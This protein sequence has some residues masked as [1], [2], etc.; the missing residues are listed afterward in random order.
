MPA[1]RVT[2]LLPLAAAL[3]AALAL[4]AHGQ[5]LLTLY[6]AARDYDA[7]YQSA[8]AQFDA[9]LARAA[10][11]KA[12]ILPQVGAQASVQRN[13]FDIDVISGAPPGSGERNFN[14]QS[15]A[16]SATQPLY[17]PAAWAA[18]EQGKRQAEIAQTVLATAEQDLIVRVSQ[19]YFDVLAAQDT[20][21]LVRAQKTAVAPRP[22]PIRARPRPA[23]TW[24]SR[25]RSRPRTTCRSSASRSTSWSGAPAAR[26]CRW[27]RRWCCPPRCRPT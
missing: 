8:R 4:P 18:Y 11:A 9:N 14:T 22:S 1:T 24:W 23:T 3:A 19:G 7:S 10:Q 26:R 27:P 17:R 5:S 15:A 6:E 13:Q 16:I 2:R 21:A 20:L 12:G 25:R